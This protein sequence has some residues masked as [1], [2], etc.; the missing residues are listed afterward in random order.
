MNATPQATSIADAEAAAGTRERIVRT[1][2]RLLQRHGYEATGI[3]QIGREAGAALGSV[4]HFFPG[5]KQELAAEAIRHLDRQFAESLRATLDTEMDPAKAVV[6]YAQSLAADLQDSDWLDTCSFSALA[7]EA[8]HRSPEMQ[9]ALADAVEHWQRVVSDKLRRAG[10]AE[11]DARELAGTVMNT[12]EG[13]GLAAQIVRSEAPL[14]VA[15]THLS[16][17]IRSYT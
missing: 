4:Y 13:A 2:A 11:H 5:G 16:R 14:R 12:L 8:A 3:K 9:R 17:L 10:I 6:A 15:G 7:L 1:T